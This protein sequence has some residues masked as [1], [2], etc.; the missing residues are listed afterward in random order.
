MSGKVDVSHELAVFLR[1]RRERLAPAEVQL[2]E[3]RRLRRT[4]GLRREEVAELAGVSV[5]YVIRLEQGRGLRPSPDVL[6][7]LARA[8]RLSDDEHAYLFGLARH[9]TAGRRHPR[10]EAGSLARLVTA[11]SPLPA[12]LVNHRFDILA[13]NAEMA[14]LMVDFATLPPEQRNV[15]W[16]CS[17]HPAF[18]GFYRDRERV[19]REGIADLRAAWAAH[20]DDAALADLVGMLMSQ[21]EEFA[22]L[23][24]QRDVKVNAQGQKSMLHPRVGPL[25]VDYDVLTPLGDS[26]QRLVVYQAADSASQAALDALAP[27]PD[28]VSA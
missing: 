8:L 25:T 15:L 24:A 12:M 27:E 23:W 3:R 1:T 13:W 6:D 2:P 17:L 5:D 22:R 20:P 4:P 18:G 7:A 16:L 14:A 28:V 26:G 21:S 10:G 19:I 9:W 11:M